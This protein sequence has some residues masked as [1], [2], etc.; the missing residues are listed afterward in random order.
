MFC[1]LAFCTFAYAAIGMLPIHF[2]L[3]YMNIGHFKVIVFE[4]VVVH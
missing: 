2:V 1:S 3:T 4:N